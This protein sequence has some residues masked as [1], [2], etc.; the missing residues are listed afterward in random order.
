MPKLFVEKTIEINAP[1]SKVWEVLTNPEQTA[2]W[3][4]EFAGGTEF[5]IE[6]D[7]Q[8]GSPVLWRGQ[9]GSVIV[10]G[11][12]TAL[13]PKKLLR[14]TVFDMGGSFFE[15]T[16]LPPGQGDDK[17]GK[18]QYRAQGDTDDIEWDIPQEQKYGEDYPECCKDGYKIFPDLSALHLVCSIVVVVCMGI[19]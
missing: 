10:Q 12:V 4:P 6:S 15:N 7:W 11:N 13:E 14:F 8:L 9:G 17:S 1:A 16:L 2:E 3:A 18:H 5:H 19:S